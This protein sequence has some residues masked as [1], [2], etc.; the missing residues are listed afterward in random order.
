M[1]APVVTSTQV[2][3][4]MGRFDRHIR[5][6]EPQWTGNWIKGWDYEYLLVDKGKIYP[7]RKIIELASGVK[8][9]PGRYE[10]P[11]ARE[12]LAALGFTIVHLSEDQVNSFDEPKFIPDH[13]KPAAHKG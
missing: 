10:A 5:G 11:E 4:A 9:G 6:Q 2:I 12:R 7:T 1:A 13:R 8:P 3:M